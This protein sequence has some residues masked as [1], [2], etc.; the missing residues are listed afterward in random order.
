MKIWSC[1][2]GECE[3]LAVPNGGDGPMR[4]AVE[5]AYTQ[6]TGGKPKFIFSGWHN[7]LTEGERAVVENRPPNLQTDAMLLAEAMY[8][9]GKAQFGGQVGGVYNDSWEQAKKSP[10]FPEMLKFAEALYLE[11]CANGTIR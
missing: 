5:I 1:K 9:V 8:T 3:E 4:K 6:L 11:L 2:I 7:R 10:E